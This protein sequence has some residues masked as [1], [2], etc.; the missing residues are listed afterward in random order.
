MTDTERDLVEAL[1]AMLRMVEE[2]A[3]PQDLEIA[4]AVGA[5]VKAEFPGLDQMRAMLESAVVIQ[6]RRLLARVEWR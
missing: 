6:A 3:R 1:K 2:S 5:D 4:E